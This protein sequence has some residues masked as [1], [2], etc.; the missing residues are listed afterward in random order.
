LSLFA[1]ATARLSARDDGATAVLDA[2]STSFDQRPALSTAAV[3]ALGGADTGDLSFEALGIAPDLVAAL[4][5]QGIRAPF[6]VQALT[7]PDALAGRDV[8]GKA[9]TGSGKTLAFGLPLIERTTTS[10]KRRPHS[11]VLVPTRELANQIAEALAP[12]AAAR[13]LWLTAIYGGVSMNRQIN[14][15]RAGVDIVIATPG[16]MNDLLERDELSLEEV[17][18]VVIDEADQMAD[19]GF[20][21]QVERILRNVEGKPQTLLFSATLDGAVGELVRRY[22][23]RPVRHEVA[24]TEVSV[25]TLTQRFIGVTAEEKVAVTAQICA[26]AGR[27]LVFVRT[28]HG[29]DRLVKYL[30][31]EGLRVD[32]LHGRLSQNRR[33][34]TLA[35]FADG[36]APVLV[37]TNVAARGLHVDGIDVVVHFDPPE[38]GK[39]YLHRSGRTARAGESGLVVTL[40]LPEQVADVTRLE[41][42]AGLDLTIVPMRAGD[43]RLLDLGSWDAP[44]GLAE[45]RNASSHGARISPSGDRVRTPR[46]ASGRPASGAAR[47][48]GD[49]GRARS[50]NRRP[51]AA[52]RSTRP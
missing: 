50:K 14:A 46:A 19:M 31:R 12:L 48:R 23:D 36:S 34:R 27:A 9:K 8:C 2:P 29:A 49:D 44:H 6:P 39:T 4:D 32:A 26:G 3:E 25:D 21:P 11:L 41:R 17:E 22:Q 10:R 18:F 7:I 43:E 13:G 35:A 37:A 51:K 28:T 52:V 24:S 15:L 38:D 45:T 16:R 47:G 40:A 30:E 5:A 33:D 1:R 42:E 20:L